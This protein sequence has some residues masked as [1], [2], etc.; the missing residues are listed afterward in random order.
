MTWF[1]VCLSH[2]FTFSTYP[3]KRRTGVRDQVVIPD[4]ALG[5]AGSSDQAIDFTDTWATQ[6][7]KRDP[8][9]ESDTTRWQ[10]G[11]MP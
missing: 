6:D 11:Q 3:R 4:K 1:S 10:P 5:Q 8:G 2:V 9:R 7:S